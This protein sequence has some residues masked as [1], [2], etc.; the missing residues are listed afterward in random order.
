MR[1]FGRDLDPHTFSLL[2]GK[3][4]QFI[5]YTEIKKTEIFKRKIFM[6]CKVLTKF[7]KIFSHKYLEPYGTLR[8]IKSAVM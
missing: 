7:T 3:F 4:F 2:E 1:P 8:N 6:I 5:G